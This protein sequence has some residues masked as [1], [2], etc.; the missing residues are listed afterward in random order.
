MVA[1]ALLEVLLLLG[2]ES[3]VLGDHEV[4]LRAARDDVDMVARLQVAEFRVLVIADDLRVA[5]DVDRGVVLV[6][7]LVGALLQ[8]NSRA[9]NREQ[10]PAVLGDRLETGPI[11]VRDDGRRVDGPAHHHLVG[12]SWPGA[13]RVPQGASLGCLLLRLRRL[14]LRLRIRRRCGASGNPRQ[15]ADEGADGDHD[16][17]SLELWSLH[18]GN[19]VSIP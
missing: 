11:R 8:V 9:V 18:A 2:E 16:R 15:C 12:A 4:A 3:V 7:R 17:H 1:E 6:G 19:A 5:A 10:R 14:R 13:E